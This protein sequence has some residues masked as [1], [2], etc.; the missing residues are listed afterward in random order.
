LIV[1]AVLGCLIYAAQKPALIA[2]LQKVGFPDSDPAHDVSA[3]A[4][5]AFS[6]NQTFW[7]IGLFAVA[8]G[9]LQVVI[10]GYFM[11]PRAKLGAMLLGG[12]LL[13][14]LGRAN[15][16]WIVHWDYKQK[17]E[18]GS[19]NPI[20]NLLREKPYEHRVTY[21]VPWPLSTPQSD[22]WFDQLYKIEWVQHQFPYYN[23]QSLDIIQM[24]RMP[25]DLA[26]YE[27]T[28]R[29]R[30]RP[31]AAGGYEVVP[32]SFPLAARR[33]QLTNTRYLVGPASF[34]DLFNQQIDPVQ[35]RFQ[36][37]QR[38]EVLPKPG[39]TRAT[40]LEELT[41]VPNEN[42][43]YALFEFT[44]ALPRAKIYSNWLVNTN[45]TANLKLLGDL[46]FDPAKAVLISTPQKNLPAQATNEN[47]GSVEFQ[48]YQPKHLVLAATNAGPSVLLLNDKFDPQWRVTVDGQPAE[49]L[50]CNFFMRGVYLPN[51]GAHT[52]DFQFS[53]PH[54]SLY[55][56]L[57]ALGVGLLLCGFLFFAGR[58]D[59]APAA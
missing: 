58:R 54:G 33:W 53:L 7:F 16:P 26:S 2:Y 24:S 17:Y 25:E 56:S 28:F 14:D 27:Q 42:G 32:E 34:L 4:I 51:A 50:R 37:V 46:A 1:A 10:S 55:L 49:L 9:L 45:D 22:E 52:V 18:V 19:L 31:T 40:Q 12:F 21:A 13:F 48:S 20:L 5:A 59:A 30:V 43:N 38:F 36:I 23:I 6:L 11:G 47:S 57:A 15:L 29:I 41:A 8:L 39:V 35:H 3:P 44:G